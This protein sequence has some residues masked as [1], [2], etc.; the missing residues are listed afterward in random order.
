MALKKAPRKVEKELRKVC[1]C[2][3]RRD[4]ITVNKMCKEL[5]EKFEDAR[6]ENGDLD[7]DSETYTEDDEDQDEGDSMDDEDELDDPGALDLSYSDEDN[8]RDSD[9]EVEL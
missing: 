7:E 2:K 3:D 8:Y 9:G 6:D 4:F 1:A 5:E